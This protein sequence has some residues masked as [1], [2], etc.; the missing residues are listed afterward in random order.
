MAQGPGQAVDPMAAEHRPGSQTCYA[1]FG[2]SLGLA[3]FL[4]ESGVTETSEIS[5]DV[6]ERY[7]AKLAAAM[8]GKKGHRDHI[9]QVSTFLR[10]VR[11]HQWDAALP[12][13][14]VIFPEDDP[15]RASGS[16]GP[17]WATSW[18]RSRIPPT[19]TD[20][21]AWPTG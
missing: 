9:G 15:A 6:L 1:A 16:R 2:H 17:W 3:A 5:R 4:A 7:L 19:S 10:D 20:G 18:P 8:A 14:A 13:S 11:R 12:A 21:R